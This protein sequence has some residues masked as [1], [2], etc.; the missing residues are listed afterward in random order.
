VPSSLIEQQH[1]ML[2][3]ADHAADFSQMQDYC[4]GV[5]KGRHQVRVPRRTQRRVMLFFCPMR[6]SSANQTSIASA[7]KPCSRAMPASVAGKFSKRSNGA[8]RQRMMA[9]AGRQPPVAHLAPIPTQR[10]HRY[11]DTK[12][13]THPIPKLT[14]PPAPAGGAIEAHPCSAAQGGEGPKR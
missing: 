3:R 11:R 4:C 5:A 14:K 12:F 9:L 10:L 8:D 6:A 7:S 2:T 1:R 13:L